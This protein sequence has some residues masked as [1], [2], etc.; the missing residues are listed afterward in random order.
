MGHIN[1]PAVAPYY[2]GHINEPAVAPYAVGVELLPTTTVPDEHSR[3]LVRLSRVENALL[4]AVQVG[5]HADRRPVGAPS[6]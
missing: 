6:R 5:L 1:E 3:V 4:D 2:M